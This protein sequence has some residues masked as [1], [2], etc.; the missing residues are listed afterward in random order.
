MPDVE[1]DKSKEPLALLDDFIE[2]TTTYL[3]DLVKS[4]KMLEDI[5]ISMLLEKPDKTHII[6]FDR[7]YEYKAKLESRKIEKIGIEF[8]PFEQSNSTFLIKIL[9]VPRVTLLRKTE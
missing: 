9:E 3:E 6:D 1:I 2:K 5:V 8:T 7:L 4:R